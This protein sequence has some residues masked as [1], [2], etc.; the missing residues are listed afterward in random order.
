MNECCIYIKY[1]KVH[2]SNNIKDTH[3]D[4]IEQ[5]QYCSQFSNCVF[6]TTLF[7]VSECLCVCEFILKMP[8]IVQSTIHTTTT[9]SIKQHHD[10]K[11][12][13]SFQKI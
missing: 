11:E 3:L 7:M 10:K 1:I 12:R 4:S 8:N 2:N 13:S 5:Q 6:C 9:K